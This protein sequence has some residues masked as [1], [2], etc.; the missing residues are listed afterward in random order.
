MW[1]RGHSFFFL[2]F[3]ASF[4]AVFMKRTQSTGPT[5]PTEKRLFGLLVANDSPTKVE[6]RATASDGCA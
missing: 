1:L 4:L 3:C 2:L 5:L 6:E